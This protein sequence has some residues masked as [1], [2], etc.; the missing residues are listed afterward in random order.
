MRGLS[1]TNAHSST[2]ANTAQAAGRAKL[3][4]FFLPLSY[5]ES[6]RIFNAAP[7][8]PHP[9]FANEFAK[10][11]LSLGEGLAAQPQMLG[12]QGGRQSPL[13]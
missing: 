3:N 13:G 5:F 7:V 4:P 8:N 6:R 2:F 1:L 9:T 12:V 10:P 11:T